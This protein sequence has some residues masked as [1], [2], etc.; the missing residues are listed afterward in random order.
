MTL[1][2]N[3]DYTGTFGGTAIPACAGLARMDIRP[4]FYA[5]IG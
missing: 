4:T 2:G 1:F 3:I 5:A